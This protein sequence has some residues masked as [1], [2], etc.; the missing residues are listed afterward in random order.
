MKKKL[1][2]K[3]IGILGGTF[4][5]IHHGHLH[6]A[7]Q[8][9]DRLPFQEIRFLPCYQNALKKNL[10]HASAQ[11]RL[12][13][14]ELAIATYPKLTIDNREL[15]R[16][17]HSYTID[18]LKSLRAELKNVSLCLLMAMDTF[19]HFSDWKNWQQILDYAHLVI[20]PRP[21]FEISLNTTLTEF[22]KQ[23]QIHDSTLLTTQ[24]AGYILLQTIESQQPISAT[25]I[26]AAVL[27]KTHPT[28]IL[29]L[30]VWNYIQEHKLYL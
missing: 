1:A 30:T 20:V 7:L 26:R 17:E 13:M 8:L 27:A 19:S 21:G 6:I 29:P 28:N 10:P 25:N 5:P 23:H 11:D 9:L 24:P 14:I 22:L 15:N 3:L 16:K 12:N 2:H 18:T 4:D